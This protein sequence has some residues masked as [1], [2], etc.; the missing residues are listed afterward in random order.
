MSRVMMV[1]SLLVLAMPI[2]VDGAR[3]VDAVQMISLSQQGGPDEATVVSGLRET[4]ARAT[5]DQDEVKMPPL[6]QQGGLDEATVVSGLKE[7]LA[8][9]TVKAVTEVGRVDG[10]FGNE[11]IKILM[12][13]RMQKVAETLNM[14]GFQKEVDAFVLS[15]NRAAE[16]AAPKADPYL[17]QA[18]KEMTFE[19]LRRSLKGGDT[20]VTEYFREKSYSKL[21]EAFKPE[22]S[23]SMNEVGVTRSY[24]AMMER[25]QSVPFMKPVSLDLDQYVT[26]KSLDGLFTMVGQEEKRIRTDPAAQVTPLLKKVFGKRGQ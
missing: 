4:L 18:V 5:G 9:A 21:Y 23:A 14:L 20:A 13:E 1:L 15:M 3:G 25:Y 19:D 8:V 7:A 10:Y 2:R 24:K 11:A 22:V 16:R 12:P 26:E 17:A 6:Y